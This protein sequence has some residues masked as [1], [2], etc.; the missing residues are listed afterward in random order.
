MS[1]VRRVIGMGIAA[2]GI[3]LAVPGAGLAQPWADADRAQQLM[4]GKDMAGAAE[5][6][7][8]LAHDNPADGYAWSQYA[9]CLHSSKRYEE[10]L[11]AYA[12]AIDLG[13]GRPTNLYNSACAHA[14]MGHTD[15]ALSFLQKALEARFA[16]QETL[17]NDT[18]LDSLRA[19]PRFA[20]LTGITRNL[21]KD[22]APSRDAGWAWDL[23]FYVRRMKQ[24]HWDLYGVVSQQKFLAEVERLKHDIPNLTDSQARVRLRKIAA[25][26]GDGHT[27]SRLAAEGEPRQLLPIHMFAFADGVYIIGADSAHADLVGSKVLKVGPL[28]IDAAMNATHPYMSVDNEMGYLASGPTMLTSPAVLQA[29]GASPDEL[30]ATFQVQKPGGQPADA[31]VEPVPSPAGG[32]EGYLMPGFTYLHQK[33]AAQQPLYLR[34]REEP[35][36]IESI[37]DHKAVYFWFGGVTNTPAGTLKD[38]VDR[39]FA[40]VDQE[41]AEHLIIDMRFNGGGNTG[42]VRPLV[43]AVIR[44]D[45]INRRGHLWVII[46]RHTFS[47][48]QNT[49]NLLEKETNAVFV[50]EPTGSRPQF[51][52]ESTWFV[53]PHSRT[54]VFCSSRYWQYLDSTDERTWVQPQIAAPMSFADYAA[55]RDPAVDAILGWIDK[56][57]ARAGE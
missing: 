44:S 42:L 10:A 27:S 47:A 31:Y 2:V 33:S 37:P 11:A 14:L 4:A 53:L 34:G 20:A 24:I 13:N 48:A 28:S 43:D 25:M 46:G 35:L 49:V 1:S 51:V 17:E 56:G 19:D 15:E 30:G 8:R 32:H 55:G 41:H 16:D 39:A 18:D 52:G 9:Y 50:G 21:A 22:P 36:R 6:F 45:A 26:V 57:G 3:L 12:K 54:R 7:G 38:F 40:M 29:I 5:I 23:D